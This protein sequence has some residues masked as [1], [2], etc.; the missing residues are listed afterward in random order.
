M[1]Y[2]NSIIVPPVHDRMRAIRDYHESCA[3]GHRGINA[4]YNRL[5]QD[6]YWKNM[7]PDVDA[8]VK[9]CMTCQTKKLVRQKT[10]L[11]LFLSDTPSKPFDKISLDFYGPLKQTAKRNVYVL[12]MQCWLSKFIDLCGIPRIRSGVRGN[13][14]MSRTRSWKSDANTVAEKIK[15]SSSSLHKPGAPEMHSRNLRCK[16]E[17]KIHITPYVH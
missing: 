10:K 16:L 5:A 1:L 3:A 13:C 17:T 11:P 4:T 15:L 12:T 7:R 2:T 8:Y 9:R 14:G 6:F